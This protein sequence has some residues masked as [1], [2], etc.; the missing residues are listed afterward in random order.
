[1]FVAGMGAGAVVA[2]VAIVVGPVP[3]G[4]VRAVVHPDE[5]SVTSRTMTPQVAAM[6]VSFMMS[7]CAL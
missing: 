6:M 7:F 3:A 4:G 2:G 5:R 1:M